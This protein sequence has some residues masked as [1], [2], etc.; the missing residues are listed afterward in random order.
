MSD[1]RK[2]FY[3]R[4][5]NVRAGMLGLQSD[6][7]LVPMSPNFDDDEPGAIWF[8]SAIGTHLVDTVATAPQDAKFVVADAKSGL[9]ADIAGRLEISD[10]QA[11][12]DDI[13]NPIAA[14]WFEEDKQ[15]P[16]LRLLKFIP[17]KA[18]AWLTTNSGFKFFYEI[19]KAN[20]TDQM[21]DTGKQI[22][23]TF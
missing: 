1:Q 8:L 2:E 23:L 7:A 19:I 22:S 3:D 21:P 11:K 4:L 14:A 18:E 17:A 10:N 9:Y 16:D 20:V 5:E 6:N 12:L 15:D 13:W